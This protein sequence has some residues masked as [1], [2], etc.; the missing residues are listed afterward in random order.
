MHRRVQR[1]DRKAV[2]R[3]GRLLT[4]WTN[5]VVTFGF[6]YN[7][8]IDSETYALLRRVKPSSA[9]PA[10]K[11]EVPMLIPVK[12]PGLETARR[13]ISV[14]ISTSRRPLASTKPTESSERCG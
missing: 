14:S 3:S 7:R 11:T 2:G 13:R 8:R 12:S 4:V 5:R 1:E 9:S 10:E 6:V